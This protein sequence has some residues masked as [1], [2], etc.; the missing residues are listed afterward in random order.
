M[1]IQI[2]RVNLPAV[3]SRLEAFRCKVN[4]FILAEIDRPLP[5]QRAAGIEH[6]NE[7]PLTGTAPPIESHLSIFGDI[8]SVIDR[9]QHFPCL[10]RPF[11]HRRMRLARHAQRLPHT[12]YIGIAQAVA[13]RQVSRVSAVSLCD[14]R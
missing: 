11:R 6:T 13:E 8:K 2:Q 12:D 9:S 4:R 7:I 10:A 5:E 3:I 1:E 14:S